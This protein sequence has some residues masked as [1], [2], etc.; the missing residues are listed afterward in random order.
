MLGG[1][2]VF[3]WVGRSAYVSV[4]YYSLLVGCLFVVFCLLRMGW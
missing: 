2:C 1:F 3:G 4:V